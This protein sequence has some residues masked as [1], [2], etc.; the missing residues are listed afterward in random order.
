MLS[1][2]LNYLSSEIVLEIIVRF[3]IFFVPAALLYFL[4]NKWMKNYFAARKIQNKPFEDKKIKHD[5]IWS[6]IN[7]FL[8]AFVT[9]AIAWA[10]AKDYSLIY[11][12]INKF[13]GIWY[14]IFSFILVFFIHDTYFYFFHR[15]MHSKLLMPKVHSLH[16]NSKDPTPFTGYAF[17]PW[18]TIIEFAFLP[19]IVFIIPLHPIVFLT[20]QFGGILLFTMYAHLGYEVMPKWWV[21]KPFT[22][23]F[24]TP[25]HHNMHHSKFN[26]NYSLYF[27]FWDRLLGT[28]HPEYNQTFLEVLEPNLKES[29]VK[30]EA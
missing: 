26:H 23:Y 27:N 16:H 21:T 4:T 2:F 1:D 10:I 9:V 25:T 5:I 15:M 13:G 19:L 8:L 17:H 7:R 12:D 28:Q 11:T 22:K 6:A 14:L 29:T 30:V 3:I 18:E 24:N 20:W